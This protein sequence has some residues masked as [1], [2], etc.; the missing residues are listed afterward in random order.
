LS[1]TLFALAA[2]DMIPADS[3]AASPSEFAQI[4]RASER[5]KQARNFGH[6]FGTPGSDIQRFTATSSDDRLLK[7]L[8]FSMKSVC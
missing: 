5:Q 6:N 7:S 4:N 8:N 3:S 2:G 1:T